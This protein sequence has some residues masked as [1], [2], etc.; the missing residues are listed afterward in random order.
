[1]RNLQLVVIDSVA[2]LYSFEYKQ[3][4][5]AEK[6]LKL[7]KF[8][9]ELA[10]YAINCNVAIVV[11][12]NVRFAGTEQVQHLDRTISAFIHFKISLSKRNG[13]FKAQLL[14]PSLEHKEALFRVSDKGI[15]D[16]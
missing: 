5:G 8:M 15:T 3:S 2:D 16:A 11:T 1:M 14:Q 9:H 12:N 13:V 4:M 10:L 7:M 6:H